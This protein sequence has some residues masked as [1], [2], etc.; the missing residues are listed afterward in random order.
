M[1]Y[2]KYE[3][4]CYCTITWVV[5]FLW[6][7]MGVSCTSDEEQ[8]LSNDD[9]A[10]VVS[11]NLSTRSLGAKDSLINSI[12]IIVAK[13]GITGDIITNEFVPN[14]VSDPITLRTMSGFYDVFVIV[15]ESNDVGTSL[16]A[17]NDA[18]TVEELKNVIIPFSVTE[19]SET[20]IPM[21]GEVREVRIVAP[22]V[23]V[24]STTNL[25]NV[26]V[27][28]VNKGNIL[29][30]SVTRLGVKVDL[31]LLSKSFGTLESATITNIPN[32]VSLFESPNIEG[33]KQSIVINESEF[34]K[35]TLPLPGYIW[36]QHKMSIV[37]PSVSFTPHTDRAKGVQLEVK[38]GGKTMS[39]PLG[40]LIE[41][42]ITTKDYTLHRNVYY[43]FT[44]RIGGDKLII[45]A[46]IANWGAAKQEF[47]TGGG[48]WENLPLESKRIGINTPDGGEAEFKVN[49]ISTVPV[50]YQWY[51]KYQKYNPTSNDI[52]TC[53]VPLVDMT[54]DTLSIDGAYTGTLKIKTKK[55]DISGEIFCVA[56]TSS[57]DGTEERSESKHVTLMVV[58]ENY[59]WAQNSFPSMQHFE[60]PQN[61]PL[62]STCILQDEEGELRK[63]DN[64]IYHVKLMSDGNWWMIQDLAYGSVLNSWT[65]NESIGELGVIAP[66]THGMAMKTGISTG[67]YLYNTFAAIQLSEADETEFNGNKGRYKE[68]LQA[69]CPEGW[70]LPGNYDGKFNQEWLDFKAINGTDFTT[71]SSFEYND[72]HAFNAYTEYS[73]QTFSF[74]G[75]C[76]AVR[77]G[78]STS[79]RYEYR[80]Q[81]A[82]LG[83]STNISIGTSTD[84][85][86]G[87]RQEDRLTIRCVKNYK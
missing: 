83:K 53:I 16:A 46:S 17:L 9:V 31:V 63:S 8:N 35:Q 74:A 34:E 59:K 76:A 38:A 60:A 54:T 33:S 45:N 6:L 18:T 70:H 49:F 15:N 65:Q 86:V 87:T 40:H 80:T 27:A 41:D 44:G 32:N 25:A 71:V 1:N 14:P 24:P 82:L 72:P 56:S 50:R 10:E 4:Y 62:G 19:R 51:H 85:V 69:L 13:Q 77:P 22:T 78:G 3:R 36:E 67:G 21:M 29:P 47:P 68:F 30:V 5:V 66:N 7:L 61:V 84:D 58:G 64:K 2:L 52:E 73:D 39:T 55:I 20:N 43:T 48:K 57:P 23:G 11:L 26:I 75:G 42:A 81:G 79:L 37:L 28:G 12:R